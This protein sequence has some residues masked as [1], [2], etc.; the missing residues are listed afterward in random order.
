MQRDTAWEG[1][2]LAER[3]QLSVLPD[4]SDPN[5]PTPEQLAF[6][7]RLERERE[8]DENFGRGD[9]AQDVGRV[10]TGAGAARQTELRIEEARRKDRKE[11]TDR[12]I[13]LSTLSNMEADLSA[14]YGE[15]FADNLFADLREDGLIEDDEYQRI[16]GI[17]DVEERRRAIAAAIQEGID[18]GRIQPDD[19]EGHE[20]AQDWLEAHRAAAAERDLEVERGLSGELSADQM[21]VAAQDE[22]ALASISETPDRE[23]DFEAATVDTERDNALDNNQ[24]GFN[25]GGL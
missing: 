1:I 16:M 12:A 22:A 23:S 24:G 4:G 25:L 9:I 17:E 21:T 11:Q 18:E 20:W 19:L 8:L 7:K 10:A 14:R 15:H 2:G 6:Q 5:N 13:L 3:S